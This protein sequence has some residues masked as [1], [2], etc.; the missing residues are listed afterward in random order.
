[1]ILGLIFV[2]L[3]FRA[4]ISPA[5]ADTFWHLRAGADIWRTGQVPMVDSYSFTAAGLPWRD[6]EW[7]WEAVTYPC[8]RLGGMP[9]LSVLAAAVILLAALL[10][11]RLTVGAPSTRMLALAVGLTLTSPVWSLRPQIATLLCVAALATFVARERLWPIPILFLVWANL[12]GAVALGGVMLLAA[13]GA[14]ALRWRRTGAPADR[15][16]T[17]ALAVVLAASGLASC[18]T[19]LGFHVFG[20]LGESA[21]R[22]YAIQIAE[23]HP[24]WPTDSTGV[25]F[26]LAGVGL[27]T[28]LVRRRHELARAPWT[29]WATVAMTLALLVPAFRAIRNFPPF[30]LVAAPAATHLL[31]E[32]FRIR[33]PIRR[34]AAASPDHPGINAALFG[35]LGAL[36]VAL[37]VAA[38]AVQL[39]WL[40]WRPI[41]REAVAAVESCHAP[42]FNHYNDGGVL[43]WFT[44]D[45]PV[46]IDSRQDPYPVDFMLDA[47]AVEGGR[48]PYQPMF[49]RWRIGCAFLS[50][51][52]KMV[53]TLRGDGWRA[54]FVDR[55]WA[56]L[57]APGSS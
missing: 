7:L 52:S 46:F 34:A 10:V 43:I 53:E 27:V 38:Y 35:G 1:M 2:V 23:W 14:A 36:T 11:Y 40:G 12:H 31:G 19:P 25:I 55:D 56:V 54:R 21:K 30:A 24:T 16:R 41:S 49:A 51:S 57:V 20:F 29:A 47:I 15:R 26:W 28:L 33:L 44:P 9:L 13:T 17:V 50:S 32:S 22:V 4:L 42:L 18:A 39:P 3:G 37:V 5:Q 8:Y 45:R 6:H 48:L